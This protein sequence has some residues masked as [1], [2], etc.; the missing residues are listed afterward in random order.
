MTEPMAS[1]IVL[2]WNGIDYLETCLNSILAQEHASFEVIVVDNG[3]KDGS[4]DFV[5][6]HFPQVKLI[7]NDRNLGFAA[8]NNVGLRAANGDILVLLNQDTEV[9]P[10]WLAAL[11]HTFSDPGI[12]LVGCKLLY[13]DG[14]IQHAGGFL[15]GARSETSHK[16]RHMVDDGQL[17]RLV[18][19]DFVTGAALG[20]SRSALATVG[21]LDEA[22]FPAYYEDI[23]WCYRTRAAGFRVVYEPRAVAVHHESTTTESSSYA[24]K[25][26][27]SQGRLRFVFKHHPLD[28]LVNDFFPAEL[29][30]VGA[31]DR[32]EDIMAIRR[33]YLHTMLHLPDILAFRHSSSVEAGLLMD[34]LSSLRSATLAGLLPPEDTGVSPTTSGTEAEQVRTKARAESLKLVLRSQRIREVPFAS[35]VPVLGKMIVAIRSLWNSMATK[36]YVRPMIL[37][38]NVFNE[39]VANYLGLL[40]RDLEL[41]SRDVAENIREMTTLAE[42]SASPENPYEPSQ[43]CD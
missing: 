33:A 28:R 36:W 11:V 25:L 27:L 6:Q 38:Q 7:R 19:A 41:L 15:Q 12:G 37:Q 17:D 8:G 2:A 20:I 10:S 21:L 39:Q 29:E 26:A 16:G 32:N 5:Q 18:D 31:T 34:L 40:S 23:D 24:Q 4:P 35:Q 9:Q 3:S 22:F 1:V 42:H 14:T 43:H 13:P 30:W